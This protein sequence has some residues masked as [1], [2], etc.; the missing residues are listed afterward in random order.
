MSCSRQFL[1]ELKNILKCT[2]CKIFIFKTFIHNNHLCKKLLNLPRSPLISKTLV[3]FTLCFFPLQASDVTISGCS[4]K[5]CK[6]SLIQ[7]LLQITNYNIAQT[8]SCDFSMCAFISATLLKIEGII[9]AQHYRQFQEVQCLQV[10]CMF[11]KK[12]RTWGWCSVFECLYSMNRSLSDYY[13]SYKW[14]SWH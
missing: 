1:K 4:R 6:Y 13:K 8:W 5:C 7:M 2:V 11:S 3:H 14:L 10:L 9:K 12:N